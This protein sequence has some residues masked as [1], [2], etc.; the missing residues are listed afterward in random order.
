[1]AAAPK[2]YIAIN[3]ITGEKCTGT[4]SYIRRKTGID[5]RAK[6]EN[7]AK[8]SDHPANGIWEIKI[9]EEGNRKASNTLKYEDFEEL[10]WD[11]ARMEARKILIELEKRRRKN[12]G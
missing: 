2:K 4:E 12:N 1:M 8:R 3:T 5:Y 10:R 6:F 9:L 7:I 11:E